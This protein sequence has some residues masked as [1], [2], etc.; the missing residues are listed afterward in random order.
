MSMGG[1]AGG[2]GTGGA[3]PCPQLYAVYQDRLQEA[4]TCNPL[5]LNR[6][7][8][9]VPDQCG[10]P[11]WVVGDEAADA[12]AAYDSWTNAGCGPFG[13]GAPCFVAQAGE[14]VKENGLLDQGKCQPKD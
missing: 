10:C 9:T 14:C 2:G 6:C 1:G 7:T 5:S 13:C 8:E 3:D 4:R 12:Q 11:V